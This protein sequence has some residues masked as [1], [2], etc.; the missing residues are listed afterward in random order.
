MSETHETESLPARANPELLGQEAAE[1]ELLRSF[2]GGRLPHAWLISGPGGRWRFVLP[3]FCFPNGGRR[4]RW[5]WPIQ[6]L[7][8]A[9]SLRAAMPIC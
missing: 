3:A 7:S 6:T 1:A 2:G 5:R 9:A 8:F 4:I